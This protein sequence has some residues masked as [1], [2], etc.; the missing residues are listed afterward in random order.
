MA[1]RFVALARELRA[2]L[3]AF[4]PDFWSGGEAAVLVEVFATTEKACGAARVLAAARAAACGAH[5]D[6]GFADAEDWLARTSGTTR[7]QARSDLATAERLEDCPRTKAAVVDG[8][9]SMGE[10][11]EI[12][13]TEKEC[14]GSEDELVDTARREGMGRLKE[15]ARKKREAAADPDQLRAKQRK[16]RDF[17]GFLDDLGMVQVRGRVLP[18]IGIP[19]LNRL[20]AETERLRRRA[21]AEGHELEARGAYAHDAFAAMVEGQGNGKAKSADLVIVC[22]LRAYRRGHAH[23]GEPC[24]VVGGGTIPVSL[25]KQL[26]KD[27]FLKVVLHDGVEISTVCHLGRHIRAELRTALE[28]GPVPDFDGVTCSVPG[29][30]RRYGLEWDHE[31]PVANQGPTSYENLKPKCWPHHQEKTAEDRR[32]GLLDGAIKKLSERG[33][34]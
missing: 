32:A 33:P 29:C 19:L 14:P 1:P 31:D 34:P 9:L 6:R 15:K 27:A 10:A 30:G 20:D 3:A 28:L 22:D 16:V 12:T 11:G 8:E 13:R 26:S 2:E 7:H 25:A 21:K 5:R 23:E 17:H 4:D 18:E 24:H